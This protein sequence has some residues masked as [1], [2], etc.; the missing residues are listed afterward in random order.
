MWEIVAKYQSGEQKTYTLQVFPFD[1]IKKI[2]ES[3]EDD[4]IELKIYK[5]KGNL[6]T[7]LFD[8]LAFQ[9]MAE[10]MYDMST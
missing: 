4:D 6:K 2:I 9:I 5:V 1:R 10:A 3:A 7:K 8:S